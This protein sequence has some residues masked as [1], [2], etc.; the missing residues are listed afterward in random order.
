MIGKDTR[1]KI[2]EK[3]P[4]KKVKEKFEESS[5]NKP[6]F[7]ELND[8]TKR[9]TKEVQLDIESLEILELDE[10]TWKFLNLM[11]ILGNS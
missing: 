3:E 2:L 8:A 6:N 11:K 7:I 9:A 4:A 1:I 5:N 10:D